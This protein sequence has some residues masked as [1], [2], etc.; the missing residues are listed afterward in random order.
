MTPLPFQM[1]SAAAAFVEAHCHKIVVVVVVV[2]V[3][4]A[5]SDADIDYLQREAQHMFEILDG[6]FVVGIAMR[7]S[8]KCSMSS[9]HHSY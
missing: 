9:Y 1:L 3:V 7:G 8:L 2:V 6:Y 5:K 4:V